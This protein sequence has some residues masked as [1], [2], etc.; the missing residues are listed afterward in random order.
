VG[1]ELARRVHFFLLSVLISHHLEVSIDH[2][3]A[4][5]VVL[6]LLTQGLLKLAMLIIAKAHGLMLSTFL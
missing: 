5:G 1:P 2:F 6:R 4:R 3:L